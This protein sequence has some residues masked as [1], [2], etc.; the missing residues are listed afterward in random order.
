MNHKE[1]GYKL[2]E[3]AKAKGNFVT[4][5]INNVYNLLQSLSHFFYKKHHEWAAICFLNE[6]F[7]CNQIWFNKG[8]DHTTV[9]L[10]LAPK[11]I[12]EYG[13]KYEAKYIIIA[14]NHPASSKL[15]P[16]YKI[17]FENIQANKELQRELFNFSDQDS[18]SANYYG[19]YL[20]ENGLG[21]ADVVFVAGDYKIFGNEE[22]VENFEENRKTSETN[23]GCL[24]PA[25]ISFIIFLLIIG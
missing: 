1:L 14:H 8:P 13:V 3:S 19:S 6:N 23:V 22:I 24:T 5:D 15:I 20:Q 17:K 12:I 25:I 16:D 18:K 11:E 7:V 2:K 10:G 4:V 9:S 21:F